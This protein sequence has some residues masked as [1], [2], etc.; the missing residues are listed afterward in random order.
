M[1]TSVPGQVDF[2]HCYFSRSYMGLGGSQ[3]LLKGWPDCVNVTQDRVVTLERALNLSLS[4]TSF[5]LV[6]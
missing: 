3:G 1:Q 2:I 6:C 5:Y 4:L